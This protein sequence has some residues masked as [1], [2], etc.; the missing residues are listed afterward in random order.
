MSLAVFAAAR[1]PPGGLLF[2]AASRFFA[3]ARIAGVMGFR[4][5]AFLP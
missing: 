4:G 3:M 2:L 1:F 5:A